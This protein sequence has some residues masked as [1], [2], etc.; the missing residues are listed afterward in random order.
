MTP[1]VHASPEP[2]AFVQVPGIIARFLNRAT[3]GV[4]GTRDAKL[5]PHVH[6]VSGWRV[7][8]DGE[9]IA[10]SIP[11][12]FVP[13]LLES[14]RDNGEVALTI[15]EIGPHETY[16][17]KGTFLDAGPCTPADLKAFEGV[18]D[19]FA[20]VVGAFYRLPDTVTKANTRPPSLVVR[21]RVREIFLQT[22]GPGAGRRIAPPEG[23]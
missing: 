23:R 2:K 22:P 16:Q 8:P 1:D 6:R 17:F 12:V 19:R 5:V 21:F 14:L 11:E 7:E 3:V 4:V 13:G 18:R 10:C 20:A 9:T 15:E